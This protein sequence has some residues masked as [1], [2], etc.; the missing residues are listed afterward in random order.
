MVTGDAQAIDSAPVKANAS[1]ESL[2]LKQPAGSAGMH[3]AHEEN[4]AGN[5]NKNSKSEQYIFSAPEHQLR[6]LEKRQ[7]KS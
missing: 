3:S 2:K 4:S 7:G 6:K 1:M 5:Q